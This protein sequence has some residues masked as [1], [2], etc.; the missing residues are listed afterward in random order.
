METS[1]YRDVITHHK[2]KAAL[3]VC[4]IDAEDKM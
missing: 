2:I 3:D 1:S 4:K